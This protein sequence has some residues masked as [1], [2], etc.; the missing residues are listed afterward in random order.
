M[1]FIAIIGWVLLTIC[2]HVL[3]ALAA[4]DPWR[5]AMIWSALPALLFYIATL[6][7]RGKK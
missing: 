6:S 3:F 1:I 4:I 5:C 2:S 7:P